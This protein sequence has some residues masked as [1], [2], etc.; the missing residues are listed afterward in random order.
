MLH[1]PCGD[2]KPDAPCMVNGTCSKHYPKQFSETTIIGEN[3]YP[4]YA[5]PDNG[6]NFEKN[7]FVYDNRWVIPCNPYLSEK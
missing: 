6:R 4:Q 1:G 7:G 3:G 5:R 2:A